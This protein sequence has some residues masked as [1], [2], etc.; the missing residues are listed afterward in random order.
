MKYVFV[1]AMIAINCMGYNQTVGTNS[2]VLLP[3]KP[4]DRYATQWTA[5]T[6]YAQ[7]TVVKQFPNYYF[8]QV[9]GTSTNVAPSHTSGTATDGT[10]TWRWISPAKRSGLFVS[11]RSATGKADVILGNETVAATNGIPL[12]NEGHTLVFS[13]QD[14][15]QGKV[16]AI[17]TTTNDV[18]LSFGEF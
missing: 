18:I 12:I 1:L 5:S 3:S 9:G 11:M 17:G 15:I 7:G 10:V 8:A 4:L 2:V 16:S 14:N 6:S 13:T